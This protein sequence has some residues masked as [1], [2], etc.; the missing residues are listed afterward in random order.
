MWRL[1]LVTTL[2]L[3]PA[4][5]CAVPPGDAAPPGPTT[6]APATAG[7]G[8]GPTT[9]RTH[10]PPVPTAASS[11]S[12]SPSP[13]PPAF[14]ASVG[15]ITPEL[16]ARMHASWRPGCPVPLEDLRHVTVRHHDMAGAV[17]TGELVV[18]ADV[19]DGLVEVFRTLFDARLPLTSVRLVDDFGADDDASMA[20]DNTS[21]FNCRAVTGGSGWSE[22]AYGRA[23]DVN[24]VEN[25]YVRGGTVLPPA[26]AAFVDRPDAPG[27][28]HDGDAV[29]RAFAEH[30]WAWGGHW[31]SPKDYQHFSTT[32]R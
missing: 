4:A 6:G 8:A 20:A 19:A 26:G 21:A 10:P 14:E 27:V 28:V 25:P 7:R 29:V 5:G 15:P 3:G 24:P 13:E 16:A 22:H 1:L 12:P 31:S 9:T 32:G 23:V 18:H 17:V 30:G 11:P 2:A